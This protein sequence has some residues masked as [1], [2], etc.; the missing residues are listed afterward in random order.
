MKA[1]GHRPRVWPKLIL[2]TLALFLIGCV[3][4][5]EYPAQAS[6]SGGPPPAPRE[7]R[8]AWVATVAN[9]DWPSRPGL[10]SADQQAEALQIIETAARLNLNAL[11][12]QIRPAADALYPSTLEPW[13]EY[14]SGTQGQAPQPPYDPLRFWI[15]AA[16]ARGL[17]LHVWFNPYRAR[18]SS[19]RSPAAGQHVS[20]QLPRSVRAYGDQ[21]WLD[22]GDAAAMSHTLA[23]IADV[24]RRYDIDGV[25]IDDYFYPYPVSA[26]G[27]SVADA[28]TPVVDFPDEPSWRAYLA[29][30]G[31]LS[32]PDW[33]RSN[34]DR[35]IRAIQQ[36]VR[37]E[38][39]W[40][41]FGVSP[42]GLGRPDRRPAGIQGFSQYDRLYADVESWLAQAW[43][44]YLVPQLYWPI[45][46]A[47]QA[48]P[49]LL[50]QWH[51][52]NTRGRHL[53]PG[54]FT[55]RIDASEG[56][57]T[58]EEIVQ[59]VAV[60]RAAGATGHVHFSMVAL[61]QNRREVAD[62]LRAGPYTSAALPPATPW[63]G[64]TL[65]QAPQVG[66]R[67]EG[68]QV[69][70]QLVAPE[71]AAR[72]FAVWLRYGDRW[73]FEVSAAATLG[74]AASEEGQP[75]TAAVVSAVDRLGNESRRVAVDL[76]P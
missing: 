68:G 3:G 12:L 14:L 37:R 58:A 71:G 76:P 51:K 44:D 42:F 41:R 29:S 50:E 2:V 11:I 48:F 47:A 10:P 9:I 74:A 62:Q 36:T 57:W 4:A 59:Q 67:R 28:S 15:D 8:A 64:D 5:P 32:R 72:R 56:S 63:L 60:S 65:P 31:T 55:S 34:V 19:A 39:S 43:V 18:H 7:F 46:Q 54:L 1:G 26:N 70:L 75:L 33:R 30:G 73:R 20:R 13:S 38:K 35:L 45:T 25:H 27:A 53:W 24:V 6:A 61:L 49:V 16:H 69:V 52:E 17:E 66:W 23:V 22:P 40:V 21:L